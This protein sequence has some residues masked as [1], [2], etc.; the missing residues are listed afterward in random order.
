MKSNTIA[1][2]SARPAAPPT[3]PPAIVPAGATAPSSLSF[4]AATLV[5]VILFDVAVAPSPATPAS[6]TPSDSSDDA[7]VESGEVWEGVGVSDV[8][9]TVETR[10]DWS[11][12]IVVR[13]PLAEEDTARLLVLLV[14]DGEIVAVCPSESVVVND[15]LD[16]VIVVTSPFD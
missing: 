2:T 5:L 1:S 4:D 15:L 8:E 7:G 9:K 11:L 14:A 13:D 3:T 12:E 16:R 10:V 6:P